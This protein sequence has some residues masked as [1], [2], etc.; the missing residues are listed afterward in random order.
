MINKSK[1]LVMLKRTNLSAIRSD[2]V[3]NFFVAFDWF[4]CFNRYGV[5]V[6]GF[7]GGR[8]FPFFDRFRQN[9]NRRVAY[10]VFL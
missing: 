2:V 10:V 1:P 5:F 7:F 3:K 6:Y 8:Q 4:E 9:N